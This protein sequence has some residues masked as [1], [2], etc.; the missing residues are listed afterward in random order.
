MLEERR[1]LV[2]ISIDNPLRWSYDPLGSRNL[3]VSLEEKRTS[4]WHQTFTS[5]Y[6]WWFNIRVV[7]DCIWKMFSVGNSA[8]NIFLMSLKTEQ[9]S[10]LSN[11][12]LKVLA[13]SLWVAVIGWRWEQTPEL[14]SIWCWRLIIICF[15]FRMAE[16]CNWY[17]YQINVVEREPVFGFGW[18]ASDRRNWRGVS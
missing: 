15:I 16:V 11:G 1:G 12:L 13:Y 17:A 8:F 6:C 2:W 18:T 14:E 5:Q 9:F 7:E 10:E 4:Q 3:G